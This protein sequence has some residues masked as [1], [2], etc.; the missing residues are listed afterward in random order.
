M[1]SDG[2]EDQFGG[3]KGKKY[4]SSRFREFLQSVHTNEMP[5]QKILLEKEFSE[6]KGKH[7]QLDDVLVIGIRF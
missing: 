5:K 6:W 7:E 1:F 2:F 4:K 3:E